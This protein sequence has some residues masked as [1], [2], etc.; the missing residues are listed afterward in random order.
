[1]PED[2][3]KIRIE[4]QATGGDAV[5][6]EVRKVESAL[7]DTTKAAAGANVGSL[8]VDPAK[9][10]PAWTAA[11]ESGGDLAESATEAGESIAKATI[12]SEDLDQ[13]LAEVRGKIAALR[14][15]IATSSAPAAGGIG[16]MFPTF[17]KAAGGAKAFG[18]SLLS[19][20]GGPIGVAVAAFTALAGWAN[21]LKKR[22]DDLAQSNREIAQS[23]AD[24][25]DRLD[26][27]LKPFDDLATAIDAAT[28][29]AASSASV[30]DAY[31]RGIDA[32]KDSL[33]LAIE[34][35]KNLKLAIIDRQVAEGKMT[36]KE[37]AIA[38]GGVEKEAVLKEADAAVAAASE[39]VRAS[40]LTIAEIQ[41]QRDE[42]RKTAE[43]EI[44]AKQREVEARVTEATALKSESEKARMEADRLA[45]EGVNKA[46]VGGAAAISPFAGGVNFLLQKDLKEDEIKAADEE[47]KKLS[48]LAEKSTAQAVEEQEAREDL[49]AAKRQQIAEIEASLEAAKKARDDAAREATRAREERDL[50]LKFTVPTIDT[51]TG[52]AVA[53]LDR[54]AKEEADKKAKEEADRIERD[55]IRAERDRINEEAKALAPK[56]SDG[57]DALAGAGLKDAGKMLDQQ[58]AGL[59]NGISIP[60]VEGML[61]R[62]GEVI[63]AVPDH[64]EA[65]MTRSLGPYVAKLENMLTR[66]NALESREKNRPGR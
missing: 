65:A 49:I 30:N 20:A 29:A 9:L 44:K 52:T 48:E 46:A 47:A 15:T 22:L 36:E 50:A 66:L 39:K 42:A 40:N 16:S 14:E 4:M 6:A 11:A 62:A 64:L 5:A 41:K 18:A 33:K 19:L 37:A 57:A 32:R 27:L 21:N 34:A 53:D 13:A 12:S 38:K 28:T 35:E 55:R 25:A 43:A 1:M 56:F 60:E 58:S 45:N 31:I 7:E 61:H 26:D 24:L 10:V 2:P 8:G 51:K 17:T 3:A 23:N 59:A 63:D 54:R